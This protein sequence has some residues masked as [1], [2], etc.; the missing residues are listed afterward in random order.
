MNR[1][2][3]FNYISER[4]ATH[5]VQINTCGKLNQ[6]GLHNHSEHLYEHFL[7]KLYGWKLKNINKKKSNVESIDLVDDSNKYIVQVSAVCTKPKIESSLSGSTIKEYTDYRF[8]F[9]AISKDATELRKQSFNNPYKLA[10]NPQ[11]DIYDM[12]SIL[13]D[14]KALDI[15]TFSEVYQ[16][17]KKELGSEPDIT[18]LDC[19]LTKIINILA[20]D[21]PDSTDNPTI[22]SF[23]IE[24][25]IAFNNLDTARE[26]VNDYSSHSPRLDKIY[27][28][29]DSQGKNVSNAVLFK[30]RNE[31]LRNKDKTTSPDDLFF[32]IVDTIRDYI[33][34]SPNLDSMSMENLDLCVNI[35][36]VDA[37]IKC[38]IIENPN[39]YKYANT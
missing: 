27:A 15:D 10:F 18:R 32:L 21:V 23:E 37:F 13:A 6:L 39:N 4:L 9:V 26:I 1:V 12:V 5:S 20:S 33:L 25:K 2:P 36:V 16:L 31:Y 3:L 24:R 22:D 7:N 8:K 14:I 35:V 30:F 34:R 17:I 11:D 29:F 19:D 28:V 38:K